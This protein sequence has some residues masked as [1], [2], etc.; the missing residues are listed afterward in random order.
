MRRSFHLAVPFVAL[1]GLATA[2]ETGDNADV[3]FILDGSGSMWGRVNEV[4]KIV[5]A[6]DVM[7]GLI[8]GLPTEI[9]AG[10]ITY[11]HRERGSCADIEVIA[12]PGQT[13][14]GDLLTALAN[15]TPLGRTPISDSLLRAGEV[16]RETEDAVSI[17]LV[18]D[19]IESCEG[20]PC[21][22]AALLR[23]QDI[24]VRI[25]V[26]GFDVDAEAKEQLS[27]IA[28]AGGG[29][30]YDASSADSLDSAL[31][32]VRVSIVEEP[33]VVEPVVTPVAPQVANLFRADDIL[34]NTDITVIN[35]DTGE[36]VDILF[37]SEPE[38]EVPAGT[39]RFEFGYPFQSWRFIPP[40]VSI[41]AGSDYTI[42]AADYGLAT[43]IWGADNARN[44]GIVEEATNS[45]ILSLM[46]SRERLQIPPG[47]YRFDFGNF[48]S[49]PTTIEPG[50]EYT[51]SA[52]DYALATVRW[53]DDIR[54]DVKIVDDATGD[55]ITTIRSSRSSAQ[56]PPG[57]YRFAFRYFTSPPVLIEPDSDYT[58][59]AAD[60]GLAKINWSDDIL[61]DVD[62]VDDASGEEIVSLRK[63]RSQVQLAPGDYRFVFSGFASPAVTIGPNSTYTISAADYGLATV[64]LAERVSGDFLLLQG[65]QDPI[66]L[67]DGREKQVLPGPYAMVYR[68]EE[69]GIINIDA[70]ETRMIEVSQ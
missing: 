53:S 43:V 40:P 50:G 56:I 66:N 63:S 57:T 37:A 34:G 52:S 19:G 44:V 3:M 46:A 16:I 11:G 9:D 25:H 39:Y 14:R 49:P 48:I 47:A 59:T 32:D 35:V 64:S 27:C 68:G 23:E 18:S 31:A 28:Q 54:G 10:L 58:V 41:E 2:Q 5:I 6:K 4:E 21:A 8:D 7:S 42:S 1:A 20:D 22:T 36:E 30:Y 55:E 33:V 38:T 62:V 51:I 26:V 12:T 65:D 70:N 67:R 29:E 24:D 60:Y 61:G 15:V 45:T 17:V 69:L 13:D